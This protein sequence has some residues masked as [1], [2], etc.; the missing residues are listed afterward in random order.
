MILNQCQ[1][2]VELYHG[3]FSFISVFSYTEE[4]RSCLSLSDV[5]SDAAV[6]SVSPLSHVETVFSLFQVV[7]HC[8]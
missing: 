5:I 4:L 8:V 6:L 1:G 2:S 3:S 7:E